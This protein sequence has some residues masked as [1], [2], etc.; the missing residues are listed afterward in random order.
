MS[1][2]AVMCGIGGWVPPTLVTN[3]DLAARL[4]TSDEWITTRTGIR[5]RYVVPPGMSTSDLAVEAGRAALK[6]ADLDSADAVIVATTTPD[7]TCPATAPT[8]ASRLGLAGVAAFDVAAVCTGFLYALA[9]GAGLVST[10]QADRVLVIGADAF[11]TILDPGDRSTVSVFGDGAGAVVLR[12]GEATEPGALAGFCLGSDGSLA[13]LITVRAGG[14]EQR[15]AG[16]A[17]PGDEF[18]SMQGREVFE[19]AVSKMAVAARTAA[20]RAG[21]RLDEVDRFVAH[22][23]NVRILRAVADQLD[24]DHSRLVV[25]LDR[26]GNTAAASIPLAL[27][28]ANADGTL[29]PGDRVVAAAFGGGATW[30]ATTF[31]WPRLRS[32]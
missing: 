19:H 27:D 24:L 10:G 30:G 32:I 1:R 6:S 5:Q 8:V 31:V 4:D 11:S 17:S 12:P 18:F 25:D 7:R 16:A 14:S 9:T 13:D 28:H 22:Q 23:A 29:R 26:V 15:S 21:W 2:T 3:A 20:E